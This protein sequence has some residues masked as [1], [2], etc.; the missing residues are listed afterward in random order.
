M[1]ING[2]FRRGFQENL[3]CVLVSVLQRCD[4]NETG[5]LRFNAIQHWTRSQSVVRSA[6][7]VSSLKAAIRQ[8]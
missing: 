5:S 7:V 1:N 4:E 3:G 8:V 2:F 6:S